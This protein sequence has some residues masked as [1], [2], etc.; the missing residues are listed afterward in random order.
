MDISSRP[1][2]SLAK[3]CMIVVPVSS[4]VVVHSWLPHSPIAPTPP[5]LQ[6][7][8]LS[9]RADIQRWYKSGDDID[10]NKPITTK[11]NHN[12]HKHAR[13]RFGKRH[14]STTASTK[15]DIPSSDMN[16]DA[17]PSSSQ[18][19]CNEVFTRYLIAP[20]LDKCTVDFD[21]GSEKEKILSNT[22][23]SQNDDECQLFICGELPITYTN[24]PQ[25]VEAW[26]Y[27]N[28]ISKKC[29]DEF[30]FV[31]FD[32]EA[33]PNVPWRKK[34]TAYQEGPS[35][36]QISTPYAALVIHLTTRM[37]H[38][39]SSS[40]TI[41]STY[42]TSSI[43]PPNECCCCSY[44]L[45]AFLA[46]PTILKVGSSIDEDMLELYR[47]N[48]LL[49][50]RSRFDLG[51][52]GSVRSMQ[53]QSHN[54]AGLQKLTRAFV[55]VEL[56]KQKKISMSDWSRVPLT[57]KQL[58]YASRDAWA[59]A[60]VME[61]WFRMSGTLGLRV[62]ID[63]GKMT[64]LVQPIELDINSLGRLVVA[65]EREMNE[66][67]KRAKERKKAKRQWKEINKIPK[68]RRTKRQQ[69]KLNGL[70][71]IMRKTAPDGVVYFNSDIL[72][73]DFTFE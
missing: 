37:L 5:K 25:T 23:L 64:D 21:D 40:S 11:S 56:G 55:G 51:G 58:W 4:F 41:N 72:Q 10:D 34:K 33:V 30:T 20:P 70:Y 61:N 13:R 62:R 52:I 45:Q 12:Q 18:W 66:V 19:D 31:G 39:T 71:E 57:K 46:D 67:C 6:S 15:S 2:L 14:R 38:P 17:D 22:I 49:K 54:R 28:V 32:V 68:S 60:A 43:T 9:P 3:I 36:I 65:R 27:D 8:Y 7:Q 59:G 26:L 42:P 24:D 35:T 44:P 48:P 1:W 63:K 69:I 16:A 47:W 73:L 50:A 53:Q 29:E